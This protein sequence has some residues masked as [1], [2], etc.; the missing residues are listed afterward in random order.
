MSQ[1]WPDW[2]TDV[3]PLYR[4]RNKYSI[5]IVNAQIYGGWGR[6]FSG[7]PLTHRV[8]SRPSD[9]SWAHPEY[10]PD[11]VVNLIPWKT[12]SRHPKSWITHVLCQ[13]IN[14]HAYTAKDGR[15]FCSR[16]TWVEN[17]KTEE[18]HF[19]WY[20]LAV[21]GSKGCRWHTDEGWPDTSRLDFSLKKLQN[22]SKFSSRCQK[23]RKSIKRLP[24]LTWL[25]YF[26]KIDVLPPLVWSHHIAAQQI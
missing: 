23:S 21:G 10:P 2:M 17:E 19:S 6:G 18:K 14:L 4:L 7:A 22:P 24:A 13:N 25:L 9:V 26:T 8:A 11:H 20:L 1:N 16:T 5:Y 12:K 15:I 3:F